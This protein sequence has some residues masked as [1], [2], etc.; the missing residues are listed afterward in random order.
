MT[1]FSVKVEEN[2]LLQHLNGAVN[3]ETSSK[4]ILFSSYSLVVGKVE[5]DFRTFNIESKPPISEK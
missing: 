2:I 1:N 5:F 4:G 3:V